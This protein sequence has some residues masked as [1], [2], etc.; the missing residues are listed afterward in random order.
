MLLFT[1]NCQITNW[2]LSLSCTLIPFFFHLIL[3]SLYNNFCLVSS[4]VLSL[5]YYI[6]SSF[7]SL[8][9]SL[10]HYTTS[11]FNVV[12]RCV[13]DS[14]A[15][16]VCFGQFFSL[17]HRA[18]ASMWHKIIGLNVQYWWMSMKTLTDAIDCLNLAKIWIIRPN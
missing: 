13:E 4:L 10:L 5:L 8:M 9:L 1:I 11:L 15:S 18:H 2:L 12:K 6:T 7:S 3:C 16:L 14:H 17:L